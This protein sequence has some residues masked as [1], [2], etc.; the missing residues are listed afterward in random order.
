MFNLITMK[1]TKNKAKQPSQRLTCAKCGAKTNKGLYE[2]D[3]KKWCLECLEE[4]T[5]VCE[6]CESRSYRDDL[7][8]FDNQVWCE[9]CLHENT[10]ICADCSERIYL[11]YTRYYGEEPIC[12]C[13]YDDKDLRESIKPSD[14]S[15]G[16]DTGTCCSVLS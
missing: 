15:K 12:Q 14:G 8:T 9:E 16:S 2:F 13:C 7:T 6:Q 4:K 5:G 3:K 10:T 1:D 11:D